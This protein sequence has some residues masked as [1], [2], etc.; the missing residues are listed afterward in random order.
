MEKKLSKHVSYF[1]LYYRLCYFQ[2]FIVYVDNASR[3]RLYELFEQDSST[4]LKYT[5]PNFFMELDFV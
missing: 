3:S 5:Q 1:L 4:E 2:E